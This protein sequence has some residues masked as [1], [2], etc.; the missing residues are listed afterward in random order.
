[1]PIRLL[2]DVHIGRHVARALRQRGFDVVALA[3]W[4]RGS[5]LGTLDD[6]MLRAA[7][8]EGRTLVTY[9]VHTIPALLRTLAGAGVQHAGVIFVSRRTIKSDNIGALVAALERFLRQ[10]AEDDLHDQSYFL[11]G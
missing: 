10:C 11:P 5:Y 6:E 4:H 9:D 3:E 2:L 8:H 1:M 7:A